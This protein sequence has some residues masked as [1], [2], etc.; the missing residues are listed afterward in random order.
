[1]RSLGLPL[2]AVAIIAGAI[3]FIDSGHDLPFAG[4][5]SS[6]DGQTDGTFFSLESQGI[7]LGAAGGAAPKVGELAPDFTLQDVD[8]KVVRLS[9]FR[10]QTVVLNFWAT[11]CAPCRQEFPE[12]VSAYER[13]KDKGLVIVGVNLRENLKSVRKFADDFGAKFPIVIDGDGSVASQYRIQGLPVTWFIDSEGIVRGQV[14]GLVTKGLLKTNLA[15]AG[16][17]LTEQQ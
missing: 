16:F 11:W 9:D 4:G 1:W 10:G 15:D 6:D 8:G 7:K 2:L 13:N 14:I 3:W 12:F 17:V 5:G